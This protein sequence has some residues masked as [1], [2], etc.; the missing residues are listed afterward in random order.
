[1]PK[2]TLAEVI[3]DFLITI[4]R[5]S[6]LANLVK[7]CT[8]RALPLVN[9]RQPERFTNSQTPLVN[10]NA[11]HSVSLDQFF[12]RSAQLVQ[13]SRFSFQL[14]GACHVLIHSLRYVCH[15]R[16]HLIHAHNLLLA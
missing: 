12:E 16:G 11:L 14:G 10:F 15:G 5:D 9:G 1:M 13:L 7:N 3:T 4:D 6:V 8:V 2:L